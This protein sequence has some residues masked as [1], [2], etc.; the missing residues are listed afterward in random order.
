MK[1]RQFPNTE[2]ATVLL[3]D[4][5]TAPAKG[6][7]FGSLWETNI[8]EEIEPSY[9]I[10]VAAKWLNE[11]KVEVKAL[12]DFSGY[13]KDK[14]SD[15]K[16][17]EWLAEYLDKAD[18]VVAHNGDRFDIT[19][20]NTRLVY[21]QIP[22]PSPSKTIDTLK[23][24][25]SR[26]KFPSN[27]LDDLANYLG[28]GRKL[29]HTGKK[30]W[31]GCIR[32]DDPKAWKLMREYNAQDVHLLERVYLRLR[33]FTTSAQHAN[34]NLANRRLHACPKCGST[35]LSKRGFAYTR[36]SEL[37]KYQCMNCFAWSTDKP[38]VLDNKVTIR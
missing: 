22:P 34:V 18:Y 2:D 29:A 15:E 14:K 26:F 25:R 5:E 30:L 1:A 4:I 33:P 27:K 19:T 35:N 6:Y 32:D 8:I 7:F 13:K 3:F 28:V 23:I 12:P 37:Q 20:T 24:A 10:S 31:L 17:A 36:T 16:L 38:E 9:L 21:H 11:P